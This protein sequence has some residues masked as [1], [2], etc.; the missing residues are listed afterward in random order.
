[1]G[2]TGRSDQVGRTGGQATRAG[3]TGGRAGGA[4]EPASWGRVFLAR[5]IEPGDETGGRWVRETGGGRV[6][7]RLREGG[8]P[9]RGSAGSGGRG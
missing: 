3:R 5:V 6:V 2:R 4:A 7:R 9:C 1:M 8:R